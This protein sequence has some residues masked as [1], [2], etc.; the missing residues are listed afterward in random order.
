LIVVVGV[1]GQE[2]ETVSEKKSEMVWK[3]LGNHSVGQT[4]DK[5]SIYHKTGSAT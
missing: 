5:V 4:D 1:S 2:E 3:L